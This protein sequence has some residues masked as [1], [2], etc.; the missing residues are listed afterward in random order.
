MV[1]DHAMCSRSAVPTN[2]V[3][4]RTHAQPPGGRSTPC[5]FTTEVRDW[6]CIVRRGSVRETLVALHLL[7]WIPKPASIDVPRKCVILISQMDLCCPARSRVKALASGA[8]ISSTGPTRRFE[9]GTRP[10]AVLTDDSRSHATFR[11]GSDLRK[12]A[13]S[14]RHIRFGE[15]PNQVSD[16]LIVWGTG[17]N[18]TTVLQFSVVRVIVCAASARMNLF[19]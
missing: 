17:T 5:R 3:L 11:L 14:V 8:N 12:S 7:A 2:N 18:D 9:S 6:K 16:R 19:P 4:L 10:S 15:G 1:D 13:S